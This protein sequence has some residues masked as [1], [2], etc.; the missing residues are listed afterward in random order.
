MKDIIL[1]CNGSV[2]IAEHRFEAWKVICEATKE[3]NFHKEMIKQ[4]RKIISSTNK[5][6]TKKLKE[7]K[8]I[9]RKY[10]KII[11]EVTL[12]AL[13]DGKKECPECKDRKILSDFVYSKHH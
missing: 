5:S 13:K 9:R 11:E 3:L 10:K 2:N 7:C 1:N 12:V 8:A 4:N 6:Y